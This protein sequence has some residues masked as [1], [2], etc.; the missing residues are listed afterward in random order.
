[1]LTQSKDMAEKGNPSLTWYISLTLYI[2]SVKQY[3]SRSNLQK[4][5]RVCLHIWGII[6]QVI[7]PPPSPI[8]R[9]RPI[10]LKVWLIGVLIDGT[11]YKKN[12]LF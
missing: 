10:G 1:M 8:K 5:C 9:S 6:S 11:S 3:Y 7:P 12:F 2:L 4:D